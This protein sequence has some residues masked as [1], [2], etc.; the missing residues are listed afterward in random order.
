[1][2]S[3][4]RDAA[5]VAGALIATCATA[6]SAFAATPLILKEGS[7]VAPEGSRASGTL[8][9]TCAA[10]AMGGTLTI[11]NEPTDEAMFDE[12]G[13]TDLC[14]GVA[15]GGV[16]K[17]VKLTSAGR[18]VVATR[19]TYETLAG[20]RCVYVIGRLAGTFAIPGPTKAT[21]SGK[22]KLAVKKSALGCAEQITISEARA[23][24]SS[25]TTHEPYFAET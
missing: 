21:V 15:V 22:G 14:E 6:G 16:V 10:L 5:I 18:F 23:V 13:G 11:N 1:M 20:M 2:R 8:D 9:L 24:L 4:R 17:A 12:G 25:A 19:L 3:V 7:V